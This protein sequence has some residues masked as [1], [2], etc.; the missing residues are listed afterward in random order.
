MAVAGWRSDGDSGTLASPARGAA[1]TDADLLAAGWQAGIPH[2]PLGTVAPRG[3]AV[4]VA[5]APARWAG[6]TGRAGGARQAQPG[7]AWE[8]LLLASGRAPR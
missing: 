7:S 8:A 6:G 3:A 5:G 2:L 1:G 4:A